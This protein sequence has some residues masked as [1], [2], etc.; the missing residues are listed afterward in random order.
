MP[1]TIEI[2]ATDAWTRRRKAWPAEPP[3]VISRLRHQNVSRMSFDALISTTAPIRIT[4]ISTMSKRSPHAS[5]RSTSLSTPVPFPSP[6][7]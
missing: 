6:C 3:H 1:K 2:D 5:F 7:R 4:A